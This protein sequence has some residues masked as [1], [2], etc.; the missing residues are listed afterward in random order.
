MFNEETLEPD[1]TPA[2][3]MLIGLVLCFC[4]FSG[5]IS[6]NFVF[7]QGVDAF[8]PNFT[9]IGC[10]ANIWNIIEQL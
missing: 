8:R 6:N 5:Y 2:F 9:V 3:S 1:M 7:L 10:F 4:V